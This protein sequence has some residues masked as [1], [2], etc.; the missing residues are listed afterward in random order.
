MQHGLLIIC[1]DHQKF[2]EFLGDAALFFKD[3]KDL[4]EKIL[5]LAQNK[6]LYKEYQKRSLQRF[7]M[8]SPKETCRKW[9]ELFGKMSQS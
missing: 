8:F 2:S 4:A 1:T 3:K 6:E 9:A 5:E 7:G